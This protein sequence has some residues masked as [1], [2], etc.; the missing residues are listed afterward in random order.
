MRSRAIRFHATTPWSTQVVRSIIRHGSHHGAHASTT[1]SLSSDRE[2]ASA[3]PRSRWVNTGGRL[4]LR[5]CTTERCLRATMASS[6]RRA[7]SS[8]SSP[9]RLRVVL[10]RDRG[11]L[12]ALSDSSDVVVPRT[13]LS[14]YAVTS[15][16]VRAIARSEVADAKTFGALASSYVRCEWPTTA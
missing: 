14:R 9:R 10:D 4:M 5:S 7:R 13:T 15:F 11:S 1:S 3:V 16:A 6:R 12:A 2:H 8:G